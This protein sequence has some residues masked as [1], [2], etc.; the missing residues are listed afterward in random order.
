MTPRPIRIAVRKFSDFESALSEQLALYQSSHPD[1]SFEAVPLDL[2]D[3]Y[4]ALF[5]SRGL[6]NGNWDLAFI[7]TDWL[8]EAVSLGALEDLSSRMQAEPFPDWPGGWPRSLVDPLLFDA[9]LY[10][11]PWH[12]GPECLIYRTDLFA[13]ASNCESFASRFGYPLAPPATW[14]QF[15]DVAAFFTAGEEH[16][17]G[18]LFAA[19]PDGHNTL[20]DFTLQLWSRGGDY[21]D[22]AGRLSLDSAKAVSSLDFYRDMVRDPQ[23]CDPA[24]AQLDST[25][26]GDVFLREEIAMM[27]NWFGFA[28]RC[29]RADSPL[30]GR[31]AIAPIPSATGQH[32]ASLSVFWSIGICAG[33]AQKDEAYR[34]LRFLAGEYADKLL[35]R[36][37]A[38]PVRLSSWNDEAIQAAIPA[39]RDLEQLSLYART[40]PRSPD[41]PKLAAIVNEA[42]QLA[43]T[44]EQS[45]AEILKHA[46]SRGA[47]ENVRL[48]Q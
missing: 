12:D 46:Q 19:F 29:E 22:A 8:T 47:A 26:S 38:V 42:I 30:C 37:G 10:S 43:L 9:R 21:V 45:S 28:A 25:A 31:T 27:V 24:S 40:L 1:T 16:R 32:P 4:D 41:L 3:L 17:Y 2:H 35:V 39:Y 23:R 14:Q 18:A 11:I 7:V 5:T 44:T 34:L 36:H 33:S 13:D 6:L 48:T 20:Y 15:R